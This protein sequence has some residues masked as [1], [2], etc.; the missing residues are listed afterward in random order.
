MPSA[1]AAIYGGIGMLVPVTWPGAGG[2]LGY[3]GST[4][5]IGTLM[6]LGAKHHI[7]CTG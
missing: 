5:G 1:V 6:N 4:G 7:G 2:A 3:A